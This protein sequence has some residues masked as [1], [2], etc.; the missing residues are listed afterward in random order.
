M[1]KRHAAAA[2][3]FV[4]FAAATVSGCAPR[5]HAEADGGF[6]VLYAELMLLNEQE[7]STP[8]VS[9]SAYR[10]HAADLLAQHGTSDTEFKIKSEMLMQDDR[11]W[12]DFLGRVSLVFDSVK[13][14]RAL[15]PK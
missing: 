8:A 10:R 12:R 11:A 4:L 15:P 1:P 6:T 9:D 2:I 3:L 13:T 5:S 14:A 7:R